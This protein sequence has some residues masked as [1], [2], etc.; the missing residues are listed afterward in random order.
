MRRKASGY[1]TG[2]IKGLQVYFGLPE[3]G[4]KMK[5]QDRGQPTPAFWLN[6]NGHNDTLEACYGFSF[7]LVV[8]PDSP[9]FYNP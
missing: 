2:I 1:F 7:F 8:N 4:L 5:S 6:V 3:D 9:C